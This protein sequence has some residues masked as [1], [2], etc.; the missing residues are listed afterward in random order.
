MLRG[1]LRFKG[2]WSS[3]SNFTDIRP[4]TGCF[5][6]MFGCRHSSNASHRNDHV[7]EKNMDRE[8][9]LSYWNEKIYVTFSTILFIPNSHTNLV[10]NVLSDNKFNTDLV[11]LHRRSPYLAPFLCT[12][13]NLSRQH[14]DTNFE[15]GKAQ[16]IHLYYHSRYTYR[17]AIY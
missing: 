9:I 1:D 3:W 4:G 6:V 16:T 2:K 14:C 17:N 8:N 10:M 11:F 12:K 5:N 7:D 13:N 15:E